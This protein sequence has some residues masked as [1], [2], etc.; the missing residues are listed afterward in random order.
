MLINDKAIA[1]I[2]SS[3]GGAVGYPKFHSTTPNSQIT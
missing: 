3:I 2:T 1:A